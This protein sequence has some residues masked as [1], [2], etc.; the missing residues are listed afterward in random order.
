[1]HTEVVKAA[2]YVA[3]LFSPAPSA[4]FTSDL[5]DLLVQRFEGHWHQEDPERG[6]GYRCIIQNGPD[7]PDA[8]VKVALASSDSGACTSRIARWTVFIDP[9]CVAARLGEG[10]EGAHLQEVY[11]TLPS[12]AP[13]V[14]NLLASPAKRSRAIQIVRPDSRNALAPVTPGQHVAVIPPT[15]L[16][17]RP[18]PAQPIFT[19]SADPFPR[20]SSRSSSASSDGTSSDLGSVFSTTSHETLFPSSLRQHAQAQMTATKRQGHH[21]H[22]SSVT[23]TTSS[24]ISRPGSTGPGQNVVQEHSNGKVGVLGGG[25]M[26][27]YAAP[28]VPA[29][30][31]S[32]SDESTATSTPSSMLPRRRREGRGRSRARSAN[33][34]AQQNQAMMNARWY[35]AAGGEQGMVY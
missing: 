12:A 20:P 33:Y 8:L 17:A 28:A 6:S 24:I 31:A 10:S 22:T 14:D 25:V 4:T 7:R 19:A 27:S 9:G 11:G 18:P 1:M 29:G 35:A 13:T 2:A 15:P 5:A 16:T 34:H 23:S 30:A 26:L 3:G 32:S 21:R